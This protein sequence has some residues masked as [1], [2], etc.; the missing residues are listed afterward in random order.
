[1]LLGL[2][3]KSCSKAVQA[4]LELD[5]E[6]AVRGFAGSLSQSVMLR[7]SNLLQIYVLPK[8]GD[9]VQHFIDGPTCFVSELVACSASI[10]LT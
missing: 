9:N 4:D 10:S 2:G 6:G 7:D 5:L 8:Y 3:R 1:M